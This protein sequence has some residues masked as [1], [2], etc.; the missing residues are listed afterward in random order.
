M[1]SS[2]SKSFIIL[3]KFFDISI[4]S[5]DIRSKSNFETRSVLKFE[6]FEKSINFE[7]SED[8]EI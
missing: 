4:I 3:L 5:S 6:I 8:F 2:F 1:K 7:N